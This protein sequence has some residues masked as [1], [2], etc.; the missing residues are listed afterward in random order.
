MERQRKPGMPNERGAYKLIDGSVVGISA[1]ASNAQSVLP[2]DFQ[3]IPLRK[4]IQNNNNNNSE[5][6][7]Q[8]NG[9][10]EGDC[11]SYGDGQDIGRAI[12]LPEF[13]FH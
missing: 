7:L 9:E 3:I 5:A 13:T 2:T 4:E 12:K 1:V 8:L 6:L 11:L 10:H